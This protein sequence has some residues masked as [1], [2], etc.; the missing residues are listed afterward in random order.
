MVPGRVLLN[1]WLAGNDVSESATYQVRWSRRRINY[2]G[3]V[4]ENDELDL[5]QDGVSYNVYVK[6]DGSN[7]FIQYGVIGN[8]LSFDGALVDV[9]EVEVEI[10]A[11]ADAG[12]SIVTRVSKFTITP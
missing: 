6:Q 11:V 4:L 9:G 8:E 1:G 5:E 2:P 12:N 7:K 3:I 10:E